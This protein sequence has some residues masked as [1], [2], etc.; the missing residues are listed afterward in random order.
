MSLPT[1]L[2]TPNVPD[3]RQEWHAISRQLSFDEIGRS[4]L[5]TAIWYQAFLLFKFCPS[6]HHDAGYI[7]G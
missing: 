7:E 5:N 3:T 1:F 4:Y 6:W 2:H